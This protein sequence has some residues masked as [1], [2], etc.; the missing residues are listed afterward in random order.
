[1]ERVDGSLGCGVVWEGR[2]RKLEEKYVMR[3]YSVMPWDLSFWYHFT[4]LRVVTEAMPSMS[5][6]SRYPLNPD[7]LS[8]QLITTPSSQIDVEPK[9]PRILHPQSFSS[10]IV[11]C[12]SRQATFHHHFQRDTV[13]HCLKTYLTGPPD[14]FDRKYQSARRS[15]TNEKPHRLITSIYYVLDAVLQTGQRAGA[16][17]GVCT[18]L[19]CRC[20]AAFDEGGLDRKTPGFI[21]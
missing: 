11:L 16:E 12:H 13:S 1:M 10:P 2:G 9:A 7:T 14:S 18:S 15:L 4:F 20:V 3:M 17:G 19:A 5:I 21:V 8:D 6:W